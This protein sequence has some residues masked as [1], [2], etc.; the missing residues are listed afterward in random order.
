VDL[1]PQCLLF[2]WI[3]ALLHDSPRARALAVS[4]WAVAVAAPLFLFALGARVD[5]NMRIFAP[6][7]LAV[8]AATSGCVLAL[9]TARALSR[10]RGAATLLATI[11]RHTL[12]IFLLHVSIQKV[13]LAGSTSWIAGILTAVAAIAMSMAIGIAASAVARHARAST[14]RSREVAT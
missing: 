6:P 1:M 11:G 12:S 7:A 14:P 9:A 10:L 3:G 8:L 5:L 4:P 2:V 13:L